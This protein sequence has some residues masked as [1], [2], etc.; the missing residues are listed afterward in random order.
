M[1][2]N[3]RLAALRKQ[4]TI[5]NLDA[6]IIPT[7]DPHQSEYPAPL[8]KSR[9]W[10]AGFTGSAGYVVVTKNTAQVW[11][12]SRYFLQC[13]T[14]IKGSEFKL[15][16]QILQG[17]PEHID[18]LATNL[19]ENAWIGCDSSL[20][21]VGQMKQMKKAFDKKNMPLTTDAD[22]I[23][24]IWQGR[25]TMPQNEIFEH[26]IAFAGKTRAAKLADIRAKMKAQ[27]ADFQLVTTLD[28]IGWTL[29]LR[30]SDVDCT[31]VRGMPH[32]ASRARCSGPP[33]PMWSA[34]DRPVIV[35]G[36]SPW[37]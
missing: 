37:P 34:L 24:P 26:D 33:S 23:S 16:K 9:V 29:N 28:D 3:A 27:N 15:H 31:P 6:Y 19:P 18:W 1:D 17:A 8:W 7:S 2:I 11:T 25:P 12:D 32:E 35:I 5:N 21:S 14:E 22:L 36:L 20:F 30:G 10:L 4:M 13:E